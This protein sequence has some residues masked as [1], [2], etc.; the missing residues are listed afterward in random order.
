MLP[1]HLKHSSDTLNMLLTVLAEN[2]TV[3]QIHQDKLASELLQGVVHD[4]LEGPWCIGQ[5][6]AQHSEL[7]QTSRRCE[8]RLGYILRLEPDL[9][10][11]TLRVNT[12]EDLRT[13]QPVKQVSCAWQQIPIL[14]CVLVQS[15]EIKA[16]AQQPLTQK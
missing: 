13:L 5:T 9:V 1:K 3:I 7:K 14:D 11:C 6:K 2:D 8:C 10:V 4:G 15:S 12:T 16:H